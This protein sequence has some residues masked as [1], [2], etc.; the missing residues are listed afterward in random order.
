MTELER[1]KADLEVL[2]GY[3][4]KCYS[5][6]AAVGS[7]EEQIARLEAEADPWREAKAYFDEYRKKQYLSHNAKQAIAHYDHLTAE[8]ERLEKRVA[9]LEAGKED[10]DPVLE[11]SRVLASA[12]EI[13]DAKGLFTKAVEIRYHCQGV[14]PYRLKGGGDA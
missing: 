2:K 4:S 1:L 7:V 9:E 12:A 8:V 10:A 5:L 6:A 14:E 3:E 11:P 13:F